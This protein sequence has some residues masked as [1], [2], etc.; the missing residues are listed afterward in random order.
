MSSPIAARISAS[1]APLGWWR[2]Q[3]RLLPRR[4]SAIAV[5]ASVAGG[6]I[7]WEL[8]AQFIIHD[9]LFL[10]PPSAIVARFFTLWSTNAI[11]PH[12]ATSGLEFVLGFAAAG[13]VG[14]AVGLLLGT[15]AF[16]RS[17]LTPWV[18]AIYSTPTVALAPLLILWFGLGLFSKIVVVFL[19]A[20]FPVLVNTQVGVEGADPRLIETVRAFGANGRQIFTKVLLPSAVPFIVAGLRLGVGRGLVGIVVAELFGAR[21]GL[22]YFINISSQ[23]FDMGGLFVAVILLAG[24]GV[25]TTEALRIVE[26]RMAP[27]RWV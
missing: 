13:V 3:L 10:V 7:L 2:T 19:V 24:A 18:S 22:G 6:F 20:V 5:V 26:R 15:N 21:A 1:R 23:I 27:W 25:I 12:I 4:R 16:A 14:V 17:A 9:K 11:Q 8:V